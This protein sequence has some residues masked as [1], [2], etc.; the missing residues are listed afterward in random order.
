M[1]TFFFNIFTWLCSVWGINFGKCCTLTNVWEYILIVFP[2]QHLLHILLENEPYGPFCL[3]QFVV[4]ICR[5]KVVF[6][7]FNPYPVCWQFVSITLL[8]KFTFYLIRFVW[9]KLQKTTTTTTT[10]W[11]LVECKTV[12]VEVVHV[13]D[14]LVAFN[15]DKYQSS[16]FLNK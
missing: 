3:L 12:L 9:S 7:G 11:L 15:L 4:I 14:T 1:V 8:S 13:L 6:E 16:C 2:A 5:H 10:L